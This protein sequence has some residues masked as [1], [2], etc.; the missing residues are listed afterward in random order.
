MTSKKGADA[1]FKTKCQGV[2]RSFFSVT[3]KDF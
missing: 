3:G 2:S 1:L